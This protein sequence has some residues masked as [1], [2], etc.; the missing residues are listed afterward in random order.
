MLCSDYELLHRLAPHQLF[1]L[2]AIE[3]LALQQRIGQEREL[4]GVLGQHLAGDGASL[5]E[6]ALHLSIDDGIEHDPICIL[7]S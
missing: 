3:L 6:D 2:P 4:V 5:V 7:G 1:E